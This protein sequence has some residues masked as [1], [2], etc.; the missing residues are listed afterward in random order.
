VYIRKNIYQIQRDLP[1]T[2]LHTLSNNDRRVTETV[3]R[4][5]ELYSLFRQSLSPL[6][7]VWNTN[8]KH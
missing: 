4:W 3:A 7:P 6:L 5:E 8:P 2:D 1:E